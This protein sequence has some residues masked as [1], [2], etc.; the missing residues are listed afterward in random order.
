ME[1]RKNIEDKCILGCI[2]IGVLGFAWVGRQVE[3]ERQEQAGY[4]QRFQQAIDVNRDGV[5]ENRELY[6]GLAE[7]GFEGILM[8][9]KV[10]S[11]EVSYDAKNI[12]IGT[13]SLSYGHERPIV[14]IPYMALKDYLAN[15]EGRK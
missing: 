2:A 6:K 14:V 13:R 10:Y 7:M 1:Q 9:G 11:L 8:D 3:I 4:V 5:V 12:G 15:H